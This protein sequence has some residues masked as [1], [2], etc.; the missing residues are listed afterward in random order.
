[1]SRQKSQSLIIQPTFYK[2][3]AKISNVYNTIDKYE[4]AEE[5][6]HNVKE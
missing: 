3:D 5:K 2:V 1:M 6:Y 4:D